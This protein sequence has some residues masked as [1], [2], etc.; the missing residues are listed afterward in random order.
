[1]ASCEQFLREVVRAVE[2]TSAQKDGARR[3]HGHLRE[4]LSSGQMETVIVDSYL[5]GSY[6][7]DTAIAPLDDVDIVFIVNADH[8]RSP[9]Q[10]LLG[11]KPSPRRVLATFEGAIR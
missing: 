10:T 6:A 8:W 2:P 7:R 3:S 4:V 1:M 11:L 5:S 9:F